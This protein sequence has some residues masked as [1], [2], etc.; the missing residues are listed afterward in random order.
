MRRLSLLLLIPFLMPVI[1]SS[2]STAAIDASQI[3]KN[4]KD[5]V[6]ILATTDSAGNPKTIGSGFFVGN[7]SRIV[8][9]LHV[10]ECAAKVFAK[11]AAGDVIEITHV[12]AI[13]TELDLAILVSPESGNPLPLASTAPE[14]GSDVLAIGNPQGLEA[15]I[16]TGIISGIRRI[17]GVR[18]YQITAPV[19]PGS[20]GGP[21]LS[22]TGEV[23][24]VASFN[25]SG[26]NLN[27]ALPAAYVIKILK[28]ERIEPVTA[29][30]NVS[31]QPRQSPK[32]TTVPMPD[33]RKP[34]S[35]LTFPRF[36][37]MRN[38][39]YCG[40]AF[41]SIPAIPDGRYTSR[42]I[43]KSARKKLLAFSKKVNAFLDCQE[44]NKTKILERLTQ[45]QRVQWA[46]DFNSLADFLTE[47]EVSLN[48]QLRIFN[49]RY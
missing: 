21:V 45:S 30:S 43:M 25:V 20:S 47:Y 44:D 13:D 22:E 14:I 37:V 8:T 31:V 46:L 7:G 15:T 48:E 39:P 24:G 4:A 6:V 19:S 3:F 17:K 38:T 29:I 10:L 5:S 23:L 32:T 11:N 9:N 40:R 18:Y 1:L 35:P 33:T 26:Q 27:F 16:S 49:R 42:K 41:F 28:N 34:V 12:A 2:P 36:E